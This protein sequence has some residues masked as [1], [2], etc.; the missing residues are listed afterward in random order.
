M[1]V[2]V[3]SLVV[4]FIIMCVFFPHLH[5]EFGQKPNRVKITVAGQFIIQRSL[6]ESK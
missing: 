6:N 2:C 3:S 5:H 4:L 1:T